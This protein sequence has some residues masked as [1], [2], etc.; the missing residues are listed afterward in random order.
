MSVAAY[1]KK[2]VA[3]VAAAALAGGALVPCLAQLHA[4]DPAKT[5]IGNSAMFA[6]EPSASPKPADDTGTQE[7]FFKMMQAVL[8]VVVLG[9]AAI[10][11][12]KKFLPKITNLSGKK[13]CVSETVSLGPRKTL[14]LL[15]IG[16]RQLLIGST[17]ENITM[18]SDVTQA[19]NKPDLSMQ[20]TDDNRKI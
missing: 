3:F 19:L 1:K 16:G 17:N 20:E 14:H 15:E 7:L 5:S 4:T 10:Y 9:V 18:L 13:I 2:I 6:N 11:F 8:L 12:T